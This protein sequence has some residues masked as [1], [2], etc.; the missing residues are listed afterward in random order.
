[1]VNNIPLQL[2]SFPASNMAFT[3][4]AAIKQK[5]SWNCHN[6]IWG[7]LRTSYTHRLLFLII[8]KNLPVFRSASSTDILSLWPAA[9]IIDD[10]SLNELPASS[11]ELL[12]MLVLIGHI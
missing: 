1:M 2:T 3:L 11:A 5:D 12:H 7:T 8:R 6:Y 9:G 4:T 10:V